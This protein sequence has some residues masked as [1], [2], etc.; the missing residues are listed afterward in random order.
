MHRNSSRD[1]HSGALS[2]I[3][4][5]QEKMPIKIIILNINIIIIIFVHFKLGCPSL[6]RFF[7]KYKVGDLFIYEF[8]I[9]LVAS[10]L[11]VLPSIYLK[12][13]LYSFPLTNKCCFWKLF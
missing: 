10:S 2:L 6:R 3:L 11:S 4:S 9:E 13:L 12:V 1:S 5:I 7:T 8:C